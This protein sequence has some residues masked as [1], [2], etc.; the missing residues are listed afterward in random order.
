[1]DFAPAKVF[2]LSDI[3]EAHAYLDSLES[4]GKVVVLND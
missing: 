4:F 1:M 2:A 3:R